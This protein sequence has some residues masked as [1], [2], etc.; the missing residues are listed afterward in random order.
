MKKAGKTIPH[1]KP[2]SQY[3]EV[4]PEPVDGSD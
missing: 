3:R 2:N 1:S 4:H